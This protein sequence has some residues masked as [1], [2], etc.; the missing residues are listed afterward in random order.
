MTPCD[1]SSIFFLNFLSVCLKSKGERSFPGEHALVMRF[2][3]LNWEWGGLG[4]HPDSATTGGKH[5]CNDH[6][7]S[8]SG[9]AALKTV[10]ME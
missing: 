8:A 9:W 3:I 6:Q 2:C 5:T 7:G 10:P 1:F 4:S